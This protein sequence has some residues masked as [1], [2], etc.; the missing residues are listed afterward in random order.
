[1]DSWVEH[2][3][4][5]F[6]L[7]LTPAQ[8]ESFHIFE[9]ALLEWNSRFNL[10][11]IRDVEGIRVR[12]FLDSLTCL[13]A[14]DQH[15]PPESLVDIG[16]GAGLPGIP[17]KIVF[18]D[19]QLTLVESVQKKAGFCEHVVNLLRLRDVE[20]LATRAEELGQDPRHRERYQV[21]TAR[22][23]AGMPT[24]V[25][26]LLPLTKVG[27]RVIMQKGKSAAEEAQASRN[28]IRLMGGN[29]TGLIRVELP[30]VEGER[31]I[32][33]VDKVNKTRPEFPRRTGIPARQ[34]ILN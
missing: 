14:M 12:H 24:L 34:P 6:G 2:A 31:F 33:T 25:E 26:Y 1:M 27:G 5:M 32:V 9:T 16:T 22:A 30:G 28:A 8:V 18:P 29:N 15:N 20:V 11:A 17:L 13:L 3:Y 19:M 21:A 10:T 23:V 4:R 7:P